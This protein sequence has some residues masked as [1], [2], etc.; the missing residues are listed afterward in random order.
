MMKKLTLDLDRLAVETFDT[1]RQ[2]TVQALGSSGWSCDSI[3]PTVT[4]PERCCKQW[5]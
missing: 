2:G 5:Y 4:D 1:A 3:C